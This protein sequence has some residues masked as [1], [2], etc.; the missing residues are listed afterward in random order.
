MKII[1]NSIIPFKGFIAMNLFGVI[2]ARKGRTLSPKTKN[3]EYIHTMQMKEMLYI[4]FYI[5]Y[6]LEWI[7]RLIQ[8]CNFNKAYKDISF[9]REAFDKQLNYKY[10]NER[11]HYSWWKY[12]RLK[13]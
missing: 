8:Y 4:F 3:H 7:V 11:K 13:K 12:L 5:W 9:E 1:Y 10:K 6:V 2:F